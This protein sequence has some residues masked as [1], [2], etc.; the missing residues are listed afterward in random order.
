LF[1]AASYRVELLLGR[2]VA[3]AAAYLPALRTLLQDKAI[4]MFADRGAGRLNWL[5]LLKELLR[6][7]VLVRSGLAPSLLILAAIA[8]VIT[9]ALACA[10]GHSRWFIPGVI[11]GGLLWVIIILLLVVAGWLMRVRAPRASM[12]ETGAED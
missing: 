10:V 11:A 12:C 6:A 2:Y 1:L 7:N 5:G 4:R 9:G 3:G 8:G